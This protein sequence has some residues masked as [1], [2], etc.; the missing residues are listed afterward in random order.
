MAAQEKLMQEEQNAR[1]NSMK[2]NAQWMDVMRKGA[3][4]GDLA[5]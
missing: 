5:R 3:L 4:R 2:L 1:I